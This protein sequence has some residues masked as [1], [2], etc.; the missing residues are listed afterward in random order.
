MTVALTGLDV[1][2]CELLH[3]ITVHAC[4]D[5]AAVLERLYSSPTGGMEPE[6]ESDWREYVQPDLRELFQNANDVVM[7]DLKGFPSRNLQDDY[8]LKIPV[9][10]LEAWIHSLNQARISLASQFDL[11]EREMERAMPIDGEGRALALFQVQFY[12]L[13]LECFLFQLD[14]GQ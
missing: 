11:T 3:Q 7:A 12:G 4:S 5:D 10:H 6:F 13:L 9:R 1:F 8:S 2:C 14:D